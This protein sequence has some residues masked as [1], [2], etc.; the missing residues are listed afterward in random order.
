MCDFARGLPEFFFLDYTPSELPASDPRTQPNI[1]IQRYVINS[2]IYTQ[3][4]RL[5]LP[6]LSRAATEPTF[7]YSREAALEAARMVILTER[8]VAKEKIPFVL[9]RFKF[10]GGLHCMCM[11]IIVLLMDVCLNKSVP[12]EDDRGR[13]DEISYTLGILEEARGHSPFPEK[14]LES[15]YRVLRR[16][17]ILLTDA[18]T[19]P[20]LRSRHDSCQSSNEPKNPSTTQ[21]DCMEIEFNTAPLD[22]GLP[23]LDEF[24]QTFDTGMDATTL[25]WDMLFSE[26]DH[27]FISM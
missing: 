24:W 19:R 3:R 18:E 7:V 14:L 13:K 15:F 12:S 17:N 25:D 26:L 20:T 22:P 4:C 11:A 27:P 1:I 6:Y 21:N 5:H 23:A 16:H 2:L 8:Q 10:S 9:A